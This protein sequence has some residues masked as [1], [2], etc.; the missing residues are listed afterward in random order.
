MTHL[1]SA[2]GDGDEAPLT[3]ADCKLYEV[4]GDYAHAL[5]GG[6]LTGGVADDAL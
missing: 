3:P 6:D 2:N 1:S 4:Y 5:T